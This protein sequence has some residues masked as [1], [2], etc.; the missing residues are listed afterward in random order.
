MK[1]NDTDRIFITE[2]ESEGKRYAGPRI[3]AR[4]WEEAEAKAKEAP[5]SRWSRIYR[6]GFFWRLALVW[7]SSK[8]DLQS[9]QAALKRER[10]NHRAEHY[11][12]P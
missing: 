5:K 12:F 9:E 6:V 11:V 2:Y 4:S 3:R 1:K 8:R 10:P 7:Q